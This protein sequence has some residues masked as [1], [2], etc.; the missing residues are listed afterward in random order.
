MILLLLKKL[1]KKMLI[2]MF[3]LFGIILLIG[4]ICSFTMFFNNM[5]TFNNMKSQVQDYM[6]NHAVTQM[7]AKAAKSNVDDSLLVEMIDV[8]Q[9]DCT[10]VTNGDVTM[11][12]DAGNNADGPLVVQ[13]LKN[14]GVSRIDYLIGTHPHEDHIGGLDDVIDAFDIGELIMPNVVTTTKTCEDVLVSAKNKGLQITRPTV[15]DTWNIGNSVCT[16]LSCSPADD[17]E[18]LNQW[19]IVVKVVNNKVSFLFEADA[20]EANEKKMI[21]SG[22]DLSAT[23]LRVAHHGSYT[24]SSEDFVKLVN[25]S[26]AI[27]SVDEDNEYEHPH[28]STMKTLCKYADYLAM[29]SS[30]GTI[31]VTSN[32]ITSDITTIFT[33]TDGN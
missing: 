9:A 15:G 18:D 25:P 2:S 22:M 24:S 32:G 11:L 16:I 28:K 33:N 13:Y 8:G 5:S 20:T 14:M 1:P 17:E 27:I 3:I 29:T 12:I 21:E 26:Y 30:Q 6:N 7:S 31:R 10:L 19:S 4:F 23:Y